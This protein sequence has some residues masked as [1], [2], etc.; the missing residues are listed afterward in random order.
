MKSLGADVVL[1][2][3]PGLAK[4]VAA[5]TGG[6][7]IGLA[8]DVVGGPS[9]LNLMNCLA[10][11]GVLV[12]Y[13]GVSGQPFSGSAPS[14]IFNEISVR[15]FWLGHWRKTATD[16]AIAKMYDHLV[17]MVASGAISPPV[18]ASYNL[19]GFSDA[20]AQAAAFKGKVILTPN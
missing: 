10:P 8:L 3:G 19:D 4:R 16:D 1:V 9:T 18:V 17:P 15:G 14:V 13:S 11:K 2:D 5:E 6:A 20:I 12:I 7:P